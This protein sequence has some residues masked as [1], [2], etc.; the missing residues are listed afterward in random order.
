M[1]DQQQRQQQQQQQ[2]QPAQ[3]AQRPEPPL[4]TFGTTAPEPEQQ[5]QQARQAP[6]GY[7]AIIDQQARQIDA[8]MQQTQQLNQQIVTL[9][10]GGAQINSQQQAQQAQRQQQGQAPDPMGAFNPESLANDEDY[11]LEAL[12]KEIGKRS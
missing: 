3:Q 10:N 9:I 6:T 5:A 12:A 4:V 1:A 2:E 8:L 11:S 7:Q